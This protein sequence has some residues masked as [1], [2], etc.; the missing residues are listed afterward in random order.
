MCP[1]CHPSTPKAPYFLIRVKLDHSRVSTAGG[2]ASQGAVR[3]RHSRNGG[4]WGHLPGEAGTLAYTFPQPGYGH[5]ALV[6]AVMACLLL[7]LGLGPAHGEA[8]ALLGPWQV[9]SHENQGAAHTH[10]TQG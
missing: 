10:N 3:P 8:G 2:R 6:L 5:G 4:S 7:G 1:A 9:C